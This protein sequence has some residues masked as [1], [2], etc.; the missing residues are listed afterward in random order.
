MENDKQ[1]VMDKAQIVVPP[2]L[3][4]LKLGNRQHVLIGGGQ[5][6]GS[7]TMTQILARANLIPG[8]DSNTREMIERNKLE[9][10]HLQHSSLV[11]DIMY[12]Y[13]SMCLLCGGAYFT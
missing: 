8:I 13:S 10:A 11:W 7:S 1:V 12:R 2:H 9:L 5:S 4:N 6:F 3:V